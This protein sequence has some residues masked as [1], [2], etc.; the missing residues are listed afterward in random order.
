MRLPAAVAVLGLLATV[1]ATDILSSSGFQICGNGT[2]DVTVSN[3]DIS[4]DRSSNVL[5][6]NVAGESKVSED[7]TGKLDLASR[8]TSATITVTALGQVRYTNSFNPCQYKTVL[9]ELT[10]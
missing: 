7:V 8:L 2:Q 10:D 3:F 5:T 6:F 4:F 1:S 9:T